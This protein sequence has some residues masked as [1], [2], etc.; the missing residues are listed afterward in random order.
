MFSHLNCQ[1]F[2]GRNLQILV[3]LAGKHVF[4]FDC[5]VFCQHVV[6]GDIDLCPRTLVFLISNLSYICLKADFDLH[7]WDISGFV[8]FY[9]EFVV[10][11]LR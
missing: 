11:V 6:G 8:H 2:I 4:S 1:C 3:R 9:P 10:E 5:D 7:H